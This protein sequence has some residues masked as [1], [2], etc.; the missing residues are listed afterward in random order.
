MELGILADGNGSGGGGAGFFFWVLILSWLLT[1]LPLWFIFKKAGQEQWK[2]LIPIYNWVVVLEIIGRPVWWIILFLIPCVNFI[3]WIV[4]SYDLARSFG[5][6][7]G[8]TIGL[9]LLSWIFL[10]ILAFDQST[11][12]GP[13]AAPGGGVP[14]PATA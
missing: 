4:V 13:A 2:A 12:R 1:V 3:V 11:Y 6:G 14:P 5:Y 8:F 10:M 9:V 7:L